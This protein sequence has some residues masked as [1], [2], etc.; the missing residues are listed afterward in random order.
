MSNDSESK[1]E[2][3]LDENEND[4]EIK[5]ISDENL[6]KSTPSTPNCEKKSN[7]KSNHSAEKL[8][9]NLKLQVKIEN[10]K[11]RQEEKVQLY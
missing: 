1:M 2:I 11:K 6:N 10:A 8:D 7:G 9:K 3:E 5:Y 4:D